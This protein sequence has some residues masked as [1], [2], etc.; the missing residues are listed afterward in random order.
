[1][2]GK[3]RTIVLFHIRSNFNFGDFLHLLG[4]LEPVIYEQLGQIGRLDLCYS[5]S[6]LLFSLLKPNVIQMLTFPHLTL[7]IHLQKF[8]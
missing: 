8:K 5:L 7:K 1:M 3:S 2:C 4:S 6:P